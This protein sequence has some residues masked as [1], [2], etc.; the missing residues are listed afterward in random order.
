MR[1]FLEIEGKLGPIPQSSSNQY[2]SPQP[3]TN[4]NVR[5]AT[6]TTEKRKRVAP[7]KRFKANIAPK[8]NEAATQ[9]PTTFSKTPTDFKIQTPLQ[10]GTPESRPPPL[11]D[12]PI[13]TGTPWPEAGNVL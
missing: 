13:C 11:E 7:A 10:K 4:P 6:K 8:P 5:K 12:A 3:D 2:R 1:T 9:P